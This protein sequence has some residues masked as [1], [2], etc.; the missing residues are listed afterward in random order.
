M[1]RSGELGRRRAIDWGDMAAAIRTKCVLLHHLLRMI[2][3]IDFFELTSFDLAPEG[4]TQLDPILSFSDTL[5]QYFSLIPS[6]DALRDAL[7]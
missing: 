7:V 2:T 4:R 5:F 1:R 6:S 3:D